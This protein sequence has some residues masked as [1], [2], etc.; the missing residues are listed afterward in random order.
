L[1]VEVAHFHPDRSQRRAWVKHQG[2]IARVLTLGFV[3]EHYALYL[4]YQNCRHQG[5]GMDEDSTDQYTQFLLQ[6]QVN[7][8][9]VEFRTP[10]TDDSLG[11]LKMVSIVDVL[12]NGLSAVYTF[13][14]TEEKA[15]FGTFNVL[16]QIEQA[17]VLGLAFV[18]LGYWIKTS[19]KM[20]YKSRFLPMQI[21]LD[22]HWRRE[23]ATR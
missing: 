10:T 16:W 7:S 14:D 5:G 12:D 15:S 3:P 22:G 13:F 20:S 8:R 4:Q 19:P 21:L 17:K 11:T 23:D 18:Y 2:L 9:L 6:S 1:R